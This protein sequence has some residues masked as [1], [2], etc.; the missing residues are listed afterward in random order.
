M[1]ALFFPFLDRSLAYD[2]ASCGSACCKAAGI[3]LEARTEPLR[4]LEHEAQLR[5]ASAAHLDDGDYL[6]FAAFQEAAALALLKGQPLPAPHAPELD[7]R[8]DRLAALLRDWR[9]L[10]GADTDAGLPQA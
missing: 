1:R 8:R 2:C 7:E 3:A 4:W 5:D 9:G 10:F 6:A